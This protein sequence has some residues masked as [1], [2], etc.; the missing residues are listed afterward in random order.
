MLM[1]KSKRNQEAN[2]SNPYQGAYKK[3][4]CVCSAGLLRSPTAARV[5]QEDYGFNTRACGVVEEYALIP[6]SAAL[7]LWADEI[8]FMENTH[9]KWVK[10]YL[11]EH[12]M[13]DKV[14]VLNIEDNHSY[15]SEELRAQIREQYNKARS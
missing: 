11:E 10:D 1:I 14:T 2:V 8:V 4:L 13:L 6:I 7:V 3:V 5:L 12:R 9:F 15:N